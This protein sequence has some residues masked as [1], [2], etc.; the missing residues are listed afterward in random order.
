MRIFLFFDD[1]EQI[2]I[3]ESLKNSNKIVKLDLS[4]E[5]IQIVI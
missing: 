1:V 5:V 4:C 2:R 3:R